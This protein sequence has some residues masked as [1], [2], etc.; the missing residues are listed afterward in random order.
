MI[1]DLG[2]SGP[3]MAIDDATMRAVARFCAL[4]TRISLVG[5][6]RA[7][8]CRGCRDLILSPVGAPGQLLQFVTTPL[9]Q[10][11]AGRRCWRCV[12]LDDL[13]P[14]KATGEALDRFAR[15]YYAG[16]YGGIPVRTA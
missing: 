12:A 4:Q 16:A 8:V 14:H 1:D 11:W 9:S 3:P 10:D 7:R 13:L 2:T 5:S 6:G 15:I